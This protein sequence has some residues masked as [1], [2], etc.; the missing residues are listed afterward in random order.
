MAAFFFMRNLEGESMAYT[1]NDYQKM[2]EEYMKSPEGRKFL[3]TEKNINVGYD[4]AE[5]RRIAENL[6]RDL[7]A[8]FLLVVKEPDAVFEENQVFVVNSASKEG[9][10]TLRIIFDSRGLSRPAL[11]NLSGSNWHEGVYDIIGL[12]TNGYRAKDYVY[13]TWPNHDDYEADGHIESYTEKHMRVRSRKELA[14]NDFVNKVI[15]KYRALYPDVVITYP[16]RWGG[17]EPDAY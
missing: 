3:K 5:M 15:G 11:G 14:P 9:T 1:A 10:K 16:S 17:T 12:F 8:A 4:D 2:V 7:I 13:G 6:K